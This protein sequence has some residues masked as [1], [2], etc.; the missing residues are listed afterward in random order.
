MADF[1]GNINPAAGW[2]DVPQ[3]GTTV[4]ARGGEG[5]P[6]NAQAV[7]LAARDKRL[8]R[9]H[10]EKLA[11]DIGCTLASGSFEDG[12]TITSAT[13]LLVD[14][15][16]QTVFAWTGSI[17]GGGYA[18]A[19]GTDP[20]LDP[21]WVNLTAYS[22]VS[23]FAI[24]VTLPPYSMHPTNTAAKNTSGLNKA[25]A[26]AVASGRPVFFPPIGTFKIKRL[27]DVAGSLEWSSSNRFA[28][29]QVDGDD[30]P[31][32]SSGAPILKVT[33][34]FT[35]RGLT[36]DQN[37]LIARG[38]AGQHRDGWNP[39]TWGGYWFAEVFGTKG[40]SLDITSAFWKNTYRGALAHNTNRAQAG[41]RVSMTEC[42]GDSRAG[43]TQTIL[44]AIDPK[45]FTV[46]D[47]P[48][49]ICMRW[50]EGDAYVSNGLSVVF[51]WGGEGVRIID[52]GFSGYQ[53]VGRGP[54]TDSWAANTT[55][56]AG[57]EFR[58][59][60]GKARVV[61]TTYTSGATFGSVDTANTY[62][63]WNP[64][65]RGTV[66]NNGIESPI[67][68]TAF[69][70]WDTLTI[71]GNHITNSGDMGIATSGTGKLIM[72]GNTVDGCR[73]GAFDFTG[74]DVGS[75]INV[76]DNIAI[77]WARGSEGV[78]SRIDTINPNI[79]AS[80]AGFALA[81]FTMNLAIGSGTKQV[82]INGNNAYMTSLP[83]VSD[84]HGPVRANVL[85]YYSQVSANEAAVNTVNFGNNTC[86]DLEASGMTNM[87]INIPT[88]KF[89]C[90]AISGTPQAGEV[91]TAANGG[92]KFVL[93]AALGAGSRVFVR[94]FT[95]AYQPYSGQ[96][97]TGSKSGA[98][99]TAAA[100]PQFTLAGADESNNTDMT[101]KYLSD[102]PVPPL[103]G[104][105]SY[106]GG[107]IANGAIIGIAIPVSGA[108]VGD[109]ADVAP[110]Y[111]IQGLSIAPYVSN[112]SEV[113]TVL[114]NNTGAA[115]TLPPGVWKARVTKG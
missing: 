46:T 48:E 75:I 86:Q 87:F 10:F 101:T 51:P 19:A 70:G 38:N 37:W 6:M 96:V 21:Q 111:Q 60:S 94:K 76:S 18:V 31:Y 105:V 85:G 30:W 47:N 112:T 64:H 27:A 115:V 63:I 52:N 106:A 92:V 91:F 50:D 26:D 7:A 58:A 15:S 90:S 40:N 22:H 67:A 29:V 5:G 97:F 23:N 56:Y 17:P 95:G 11:L 102:Q 34:D 25:N 42:L 114:T 61:A 99:I 108:A 3:L 109:F 62:E 28:V 14:E 24:N 107:T 98:T 93:C 55:F 80:N 53:L 72:S 8:M 83:P 44:A 68:D 73:I 9:L 104:A 103:I 78:Y 81:A 33:G 110:P 20:T 1:D 2:N 49:I 4:L 74:W 88:R 59:P 100:N 35:I 84:P 69:Y 79:W 43:I 45:P 57:Q 54:K 66:V 65:R 12:A 41:M 16:T 77:D 36:I 71:T 39:A 113:T 82:N 13:Q 32:T 89:Y